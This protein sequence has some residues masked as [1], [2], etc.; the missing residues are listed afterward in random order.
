MNYQPVIAG[1]QS[2][3][4][5]EFKDFS[6]NSINEDNAAGTLVPVVRQI[7]PNSTNTFSAAGPSNASELEYITYSDDEE[8]VGVEAAFN[9]LETSIT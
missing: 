4:S 9:N 8:D 1:N 6:D 7:S 5:T 3:P 2:N